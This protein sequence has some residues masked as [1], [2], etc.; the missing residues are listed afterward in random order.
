MV[1][2][3]MINIFDTAPLVVTTKILHKTQNHD[4]ML[5]DKRAELLVKSYFVHQTKYDLIILLIGD[6]DKLDV[7]NQL[8]KTSRL[9]F[10]RWETMIMITF[11]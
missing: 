8:E 5:P 2:G 10:R 6:Q 3:V 1:N 9:P 4:G 11:F 7:T